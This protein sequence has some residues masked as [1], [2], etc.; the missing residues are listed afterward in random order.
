MLKRAV[1]GY[2]LRLIAALAFGGERAPH[3]PFR[4][5][6]P[7][8]RA[9]GRDAAEARGDKLARRLVRDGAAA[10]TLTARH[11]TPYNDRET[12]MCLRALAN[13]AR[14]EIHRDDVTGR[15]IKRH[16]IWPKALRSA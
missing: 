10:G 5:P 9:R 11:G 2:A 8:R 15:I 6:T 12:M 16:V 7:E 4:G 13:G 1:K 3:K 14:V